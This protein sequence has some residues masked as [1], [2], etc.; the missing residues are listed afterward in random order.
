[1]DIE[2]N[3][4]K[5]NDLD[6]DLDIF[7]FIDL[8]L[9]NDDEG[10]EYVKKNDKGNCTNCESKNLIKTNGSIICK[11]CGIINEEILDRGIEFSNNENSNTRVGCASNHFLPKSSMGTKIG[12]RNYS[13][14]SLLQNRWYRMIYKERSLLA[15]LTDIEEKCKKYG[16]NKPVI[17]NSKILFKKINDSKHKYGKNKGKQ[18]IIRGVNR[19]SLIAACIYHG[20]E[21]QGI[22]R[23]QKEIAEI[24]SLEVTNV[25]KGCRKLRDI[26]EEDDILSMFEPSDSIQYI[27][28]YSKKLNLD[29][30]YVKICKTLSNN[31]KKL[32]IASDHQPPSIAAGS[33]I[34]VSDAFNLN[35]NIKE[36]S[37]KFKIS[38]VTIKKTYKKI[39]DF[40]DIL[41][42]DKL[43]DNKLKELEEYYSNI[44]I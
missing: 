22:P 9:N 19:N 26:L 11:D 30:K 38:E 41:F 31:I 15:V 4:D 36:I 3:L 43:V 25:T 12:G 21:M 1:M 39:N 13:R 16:I 14:M 5:I 29:D 17:D 28:R 2:K 35:L 8:V 10:K 27:D 44:K 32:D 24:C 6:N 40:K 33:I 7:D 18:I 23:S 34:L 42:N 20:A 37:T